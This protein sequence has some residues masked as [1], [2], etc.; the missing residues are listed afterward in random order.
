[1]SFSSFLIK[2]PCPDS[3]SV[4]SNSPHGAVPPTERR[5]TVEKEPEIEK[6]LELEGQK[7][8]LGLT[9]RTGG[10]EKGKEVEKTVRRLNLGRSSCSRYSF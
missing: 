3:F 10:G 1:M 4:P 5:S 6:S 2:W 8:K 9:Q 7:P